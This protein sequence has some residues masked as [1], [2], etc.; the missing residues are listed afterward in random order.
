MEVAMEQ[1]LDHVYRRIIT[2]A[3][4]TVKQKQELRGLD[5]EKRHE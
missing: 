2:E 1:S 5:F 3:S 4:S